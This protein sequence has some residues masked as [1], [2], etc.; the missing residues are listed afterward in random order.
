[1]AGRY[2]L[3]GTATGRRETI[4]TSP[5][6]ARPEYLLLLPG[7]SWLSLVAA[8][9][10]AG[11]F[12]L[13]TVKLVIPALICGVLAVAM[14]IAWVWEL[15]PGPAYPPQ[16][17]GAGVKLPVYVTG[18]TSHSWW[19]TVVFLLID[20]A[21]FASLVFSYL[22][23]WTVNPGAWPPEDVQVP[24]LFW[25]AVAAIVL[26]GSGAAMA[27][28]NRALGTENQRDP[29]VMRI[30]LAVG[31]LL[32][33]ASLWIAFHDLWQTGLR[34]DQQA[35]GAMVY[36]ILGYQGLHAAV[37]LIM[38]CYLLARS[39]YGLLDAVRRASFDNARL[40]WYYT[41]GQGLVALATIHLFPRLIH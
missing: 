36:T 13:L 35:Y 41:V 6:D 38:A 28:A 8:F 21:L 33:M 20:G 32:M 19:A 10:T 24:A 9:G 12:L 29:W 1:V 22:F 14:V 2:F 7:P 16:D 23:L 27:C 26:A 4:V 31:M 5:V 34:P 30:A 11:F 17:I 25:P 18:P 37:L 3:P 40:L 39:A 15:D